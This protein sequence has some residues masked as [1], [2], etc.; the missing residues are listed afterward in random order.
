M[1]ILSGNSLIEMRGLGKH[2]SRGT[3]AAAVAECVAGAAGQDSGFVLRKLESRFREESPRM[4]AV[5][6]PV[7]LLAIVIGL[8]SSPLSRPVLAHRHAIDLKTEVRR[9]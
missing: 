7:P 5:L 3:I 8:T 1:H 4:I 6:L 9:E 2:V